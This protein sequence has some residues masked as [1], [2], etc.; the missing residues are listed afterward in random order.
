MNPLLFPGR[1]RDAN[2]Y[3][4]EDFDAVYGLREY[5]YNDAWDELYHGGADFWGPFEDYW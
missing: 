4:A 3:T 1:G 2:L 5:G